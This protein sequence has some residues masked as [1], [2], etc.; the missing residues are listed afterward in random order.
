MGDCARSSRRARA[1]PEEPRSSGAG[2]VGKPLVSESE[3]S[4]ARITW[5]QECASREDAPTL[6]VDPPGEAR[7]LAHTS[8]GGNLCPVSLGVGCS[9]RAVEPADGAVVDVELRL[10]W[11]SMTCSRRSPR[12][13]FVIAPPSCEE[14]LVADDT[15]FQRR[16]AIDDLEASGENPVVETKTTAGPTS[17]HVPSRITV[18]SAGG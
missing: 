8:A 6:D 15:A 4:T 11:V 16:F 12:N 3:A 1:V 18:T 7:V 13:V 14:Q 9:R 2:R 5:T 17:G 10:V